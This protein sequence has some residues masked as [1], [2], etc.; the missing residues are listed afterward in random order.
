M[1][2]SLSR[3]FLYIFYAPLAVVF[4]CKFSRHKDKKIIPAVALL[5]IFYFK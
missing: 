4:K 1:T 3:S 5:D 2:V